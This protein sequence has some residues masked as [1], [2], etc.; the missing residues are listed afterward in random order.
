MDG[1]S[2]RD[3]SI[4]IQ[5]LDSCIYHCN[6]SNWGACSTHSPQSPSYKENERKKIRHYFMLVSTFPWII[7]IYWVQTF[8]RRYSLLWINLV[9]YHYP[10]CW[11]WSFIICHAKV[12]D[13]WNF[14][15]FFHCI[16]ALYPFF[17]IPWK[18]FCIILMWK[19]NRA[20][21]IT[22]EFIKNRYEYCANA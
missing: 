2:H 6:V 10:I 15:C 8:M 5:V 13:V 19:V 7:Y 16:G 9:S 11:T 17:E 21:N 3:H 4:Q 18:L 1:G 20:L 22:N 12:N 14:F